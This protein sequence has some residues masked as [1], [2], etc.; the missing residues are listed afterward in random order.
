MYFGVPLE[1]SYQAATS[2]GQLHFAFLCI[3]F[4]ELHGLETEGISRV[5]GNAVVIQDWIKCID[6]GKPLVFDENASVHDACGILKN[7]LSKLPE[8]LIP[9]SHT[10][11]ISNYDTDEQYLEKI[12]NFT[13]AL[14]K[15]NQIMIL[16]LLGLLHRIS[17]K[18]HLNKMSSKSLASCW[19][20]V[21]FEEPDATDALSIQK[22]ADK[23]EM[24][25]SGL[26]VY[27][28]TSMLIKTLVVMIENHSVISKHIKK[29]I[30]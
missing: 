5:S 24:S 27:E 20:L 9:A 22:E 14:P 15:T 8:H 1:E 12:I 19:S 21:V 29:L 25:P 6:S 18:S 10:K 16:K 23:L 26:A 3:T 28:T 13:K 2:A 11:E 4:I 17:I 7:Y 30:M